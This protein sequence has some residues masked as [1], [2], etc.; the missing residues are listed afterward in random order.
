[1]YAYWSGGRGGGDYYLKVTGIVG[2]QNFR[3]QIYIDNSTSTFGT[4]MLLVK[5]IVYR[6]NGPKIV[7]LPPKYATEGDTTMF[8][9]GI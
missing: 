9:Y 7:E 4:L 2:T 5:V 6:P 8:E 1:M 3:C